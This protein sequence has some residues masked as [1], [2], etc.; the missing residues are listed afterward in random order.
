[1]RGTRPN[2]SG[3]RVL[4]VHSERQR[5][6]DP[7]KFQGSFGDSEFQLLG[8]SSRHYSEWL[9]EGSFFRL[10]NNL[11]TEAPSGLVTAP[12]KRAAHHYLIRKRHL[13]SSL[14]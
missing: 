2:L 12:K 11:M 5:D 3:A 9:P 7:L 6:V 1:M 14:N 8:P 10:S 4:F 13:I